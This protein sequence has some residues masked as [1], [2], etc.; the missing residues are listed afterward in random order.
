MN[1]IIKA[2]YIFF[3]VQGIRGW[4]D[5]PKGWG[6]RSRPRHNVVMTEDNYDSGNRFY[7]SHVPLLFMGTAPSSKSPSHFPHR[8]GK[9]IA[10]IL[11]CC[12]F[13]WGGGWVVL[14]QRSTSVVPR[15]RTDDF[16]VSTFTF[17]VTNV[18]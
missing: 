2:E 5:E 12:C 14:A 17:R 18:A 6:T 15:L 1:I 16:A 9:T 10:K 13:S 7:F 3:S 11:R 4:W 8:S